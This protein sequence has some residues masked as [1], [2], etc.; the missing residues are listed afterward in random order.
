[1]AI[2]Q[3]NKQKKKKDALVI[4]PTFYPINVDDL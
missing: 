3:R 4:T 2:L 1:M